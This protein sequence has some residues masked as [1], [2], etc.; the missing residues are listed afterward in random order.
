MEEVYAQ[1]LRHID[2]VASLYAEQIAA[3]R[4]FLHE[5]PSGASSWVLV[6]IK[7]LHDFPSGPWN[8]KVSVPKNVSSNE[9]YLLI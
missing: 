9:Q 2:F 1:G 6:A 4:Y 7:A 8:A 5:D 3:E